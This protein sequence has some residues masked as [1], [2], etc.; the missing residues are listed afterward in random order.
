M[1]VFGGSRV[2][3]VGPVPPYRGGISQYTEQLHSA[4]ALQGA[5]LAISYSRQYPKVLYPG[6]S[7]KDGASYLDDV[8]YII[9]SINPISWWR[10]AKRIRAFKPDLIVLQW[11]HVYWTPLTLYLKQLWKRHGIR[12]VMI[13]HNV[14]E[15]ESKGWKLRTRNFALSGFQEFLVHST[16]ETIVLAS[17]FPTARIRVHPI[18]AYTT[19]PEPD[20]QLPRRA[21]TELLFF[22]LVRHYKGLDVLLRSLG[23]LKDQDFHLTVAGEIWEGLEEY[24]GIVEA[25]GISDR[26]D[27]INGYVSNQE[28]ANLFSRADAVVLPYRSASGSA[29]ASLAL[30]YCKP[31]VASRVGGFPDVVSP[32]R[33][34]ILVEP[35][36][37]SSLADGLRHIFSGAPW[38]NADALA[39]AKARLTWG[40]LAAELKR[41]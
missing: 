30:N 35:E 19:F 3:I 16:P 5:S 14:V 21:K 36:D 10:A 25:A 20:R 9:D 13:C 39:E 37:E 22:G 17:A 28:A 31:M 23:G 2:V 40:S 26:V 1:K 41:S 24:T 4:L 11:W 32:G 29:V 8:E 12:T 34:G 33:T 18:P 7:D 27:F 15:H 38:F 6:G